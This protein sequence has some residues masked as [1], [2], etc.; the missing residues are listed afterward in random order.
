[1]NRDDAVARLVALLAEAAIA[2]K[3]RRPTR[4][5]LGSKQRR[6]DTKVKRGTTKRLRSG[7][8]QLD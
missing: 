7:K 5:T 3:T 4:P 8:P 1:M 2:P 6:L